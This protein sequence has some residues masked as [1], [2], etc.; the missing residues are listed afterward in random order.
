MS[1]KFKTT[2]RANPADRTQKKHYAAPVKT[3]NKDIEDIIPAIEKMST[4]SGADISAVL[5]SL[6]D[7]TPDMLA[8]GYSVKLGDLGTLRVSFSSEGQATPEEVTVHTIKGQKVLF[9]PGKKLKK[10][11]ENLTFNKG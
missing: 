6:L 7:V 8:D 3:G 10:M 2:E 4:V 9:T 5:Y 1:I 11:L